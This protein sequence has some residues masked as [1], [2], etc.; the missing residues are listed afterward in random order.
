MKTISPQPSLRKSLL[1]DFRRVAVV[2]HSH[3]IHDILV[4]SNTLPATPWHP[5]SIRQKPPQP[6]DNSHL[7]SPYCVFPSGRLNAHRSPQR[8]QRLRHHTLRNSLR[9]YRSSHPTNESLSSQGSF[10]TAHSIAV[11]IS[12]FR[13]SRIAATHRR[14]TRTS[15]TFGTYNL[16]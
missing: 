11:D 3:A 15:L 12:N 8:G 5:A 14:S 10:S 6:F 7:S 16:E 2:A 9:V 4:A 1:S 13:S